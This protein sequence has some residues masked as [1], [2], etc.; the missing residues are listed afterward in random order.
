MN[1]TVDCP[2]CKGSGKITICTECK[3]RGIVSDIR[4]GVWYGVPC[5]NCCEQPKM[6]LDGDRG[7]Y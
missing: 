6:I 7:N 1:Q 5:P 2:H 4:N 3:G